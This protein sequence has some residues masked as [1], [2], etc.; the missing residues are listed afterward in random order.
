MKK[1]ALGIIAAITASTAYSAIE[2]PK[3]VWAD[4]LQQIY[5]DNNG[6]L[7]APWV[8]YGTGAEPSRQWAFLFPNYKTGPYYELMQLAT[9]M[10]ALSCSSFDPSSQADQWLVTPEFEVTG[11][12]LLVGYKIYAQGSNAASTYKIYVSENGGAEKS[13]FG[14]T[15]YISSNFKGSE[16]G[17]KI[18]HRY[19]ALKG[20]EGK[21]I[22]L[23]FVNDSQD[24]GVLG[25][26]NIEVLPYKA[27][28]INHTP[29]FVSPNEETQVRFTVNMATPE[30]VSGFKAVLETST[31]ETQ[32]YNSTKSYS[33]T[34]TQQKFSFPSK[35][36][37]EEG[38]TITYTVTI[39]PKK[40]GY[41]PIVIT[42]AIAAGEPSFAP[43][44]LV[45]EFTGTWCGYCPRGTAALEYYRNYYTGEE[46]PK[47][48]GVAVHSGD[49]MQILDNM[50][51]EDLN[52]LSIAPNNLPAALFNRQFAADPADVEAL[53]RMLSKKA[54]VSG[55]ITDGWYDVNL[56]S[57]KINFETKLSIN[58]MNPEINASVIL[59]ENNVTGVGADYNQTDYYYNATIDEMMEEYG[60]EL[61]QYFANFTDRAVNFV[62]F[63]EMVY[64]DVARACYPSINGT[65][66]RSG[67]WNAGETVKG[68]IGFDI[69]KSVSD[70]KSLDIVLVLTDA[71]N[72]QVL[73]ADRV[74]ITDLTAGVAACGSDN[75]VKILKEGELL[76]I[77]GA[78]GG[79]LEIYSADGR[80]IF[81][82]KVADNSLTIPSANLNGVAIVKVK[83]LDS[84]LSKKII[85]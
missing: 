67:Q 21:K 74:N 40:D 36:T 77:L 19:F 47:V 41:Q 38:A 50:Y 54:Y 55:N 84:A 69:P 78:A 30:T 59:S 39:T 18:A 22:R 35:I 1:I 2:Y 25:F 80:L 46:K 23:A 24:K 9:D 71:V 31:G 26:S 56:K 15:P 13:D 51:Y 12:N 33:T 57:G 53:D 75:N 29:Q 27:E 72:G 5:F 70:P 11:N 64:N 73:S 16:D 68:S 66:I 4:D 79:S 32:T 8:T 82:S 42:G 81:S 34:D 83:T 85:F 62:P 65:P 61:G 3:T 28:V 17:V 48:I 58:M 63:D 52:A 60:D 20:Y 14:E 7:K 76:K 45:E 49:V 10:V 43:V 37:V 44:G 6:T